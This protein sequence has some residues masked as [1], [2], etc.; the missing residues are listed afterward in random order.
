M[1]E[2]PPWDDLRDGIGCPF[3]LP[4]THIGKF[5]IFVETLS[6]STL[7]LPREQTYRGACALIFDPR[8]VC[9]IDELDRGEWARLA[10]DIWAAERAVYRAFEPD[11]VNV[12]CL[13]MTV[14]HL[15]WHIIPRYKD[16]GR[17]GGP[18]WTTTREEMP[19]TRLDE[20]EYAS[21]AARIAAALEMNA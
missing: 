13:G 15:H 2:L 10:D 18:I 8:H 14:P 4:R 5:M 11:H 9:R 12:E 17:F 3:E 19:R 6:I 7:Y 20:A 1:P 16:D 21:L